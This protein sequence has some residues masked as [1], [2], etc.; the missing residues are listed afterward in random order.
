MATT[1][2]ARAKMAATVART[3]V[4]VSASDKT[5]RVAG[6]R[7]TQGPTPWSCRRWTEAGMSML[8]QLR[9]GKSEKLG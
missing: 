3:V 4:M 8:Y 9:S 1:R 5:E 2:D 7:L 6:C